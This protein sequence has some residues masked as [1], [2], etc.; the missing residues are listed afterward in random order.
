MN[1]MKKYINILVVLLTI[2]VMGMSCKKTIP[3]TEPFDKFTESTV[4]SSRASADAF[5][6]NAYNAIV[7]GYYSS[8]IELD[9]YTNNSIQ[10]AGTA[11]T[12]EEITRDNDFGFN[13]FSSIRR[14]N[15]IISEVALS[16]TLTDVDKT[17]LIAEAKFLRA[18]T[19]FWL[20]KRFGRIVWVDHLIS[21]D[22][23]DFTLPLETVPSTWSLI[24]QDCNDAIA[25]L[26]K[27]SL[28]GRANKFAAF[29]LK[30]YIGLQAAAYTGDASYFQQAADAADSVIINGGYILDANYE[31]LFNEQGRYSKEHI[32]ATYKSAVNYVI[33][34]ANDAQTVVP[35]TNNDYLKTTGS[36]P[37]FK[38][39]R[40]FEAW[41]SNAPSQNIVDDYLVID[42]VSGQAV[43]WDQSSQFTSN[44]TKV[45]GTDP[46]AID[47]GNVTGTGRINE[48]MYQN[49]DKRFAGSIVYDS[50]QWFGE[51][52]TTA[53]KGNLNRIVNGGLATCCVPI[54]NYFWRKG[55][56]NVNPRVYANIPSDYHWVVF[57]LGQIYL[58]KAEALLALNKIP[59]AVAALNVT[60]TFH[61]G[62]P[63]STAS[64]S[65][66]AWIDYK[67]ERRVE[68]AKEGQGDYYF[69]LLRW[70][71][72]GY[73]ANSGRAP[74]AKIVELEDPATFISI[75]HN[76]KHYEVIKCIF[77]N[78]HIRVFD[79]TRRY[80]LPIPQAQIVR[81]PKL[82][83]NPGW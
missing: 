13:K 75:S 44:V 17:Q 12:R 30:S 50:C 33:S 42:N 63:P 67:R 45:T 4:W 37:A 20:A 79:N 54:T 43:R 72:Y 9:C 64:S 59:Q 53:V 83:Q 35:N 66:Q 25:G 14:C 58:N 2:F 34:S 1:I 16:K 19:N 10:S 60:R 65:A 68:M 39:D 56:Y 73:D 70:G 29:A 82:T 62:L 15:L 49:R 46:N 26:P 52:C 11:I 38:V 8:N 69:S 28:A 61:G 78:N 76:R 77:N 31:G 40:I 71:K 41:G 22:T 81:N 48:I 23:T 5:V 3:F 80:L 6:F 7:Y 36:G 32:L 51:L 24:M 74:G 47:A 55:V 27:T 57:R 18:M 21:I